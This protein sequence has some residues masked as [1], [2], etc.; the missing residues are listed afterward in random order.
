MGAQI[1]VEGLTLNA[2]ARSDGGYQL[3]IP[4]SVRSEIVMRAELIGY[5]SLTKRVSLGARSLRRDFALHSSVPLESSED[6]NAVGG[7]RRHRRGGRRTHE[8]KSGRRLRCPRPA[9]VALRECSH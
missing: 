1:H 3:T 5:A 9:T 6:R 2:L 4:T 7:Q 8:N